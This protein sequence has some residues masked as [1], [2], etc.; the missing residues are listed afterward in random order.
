M[1]YIDDTELGWLPILETWI[2]NENFKW[3]PE[4][5]EYIFNLFKTY[6]DPCLKHVKKNLIEAMAQV[7][8]IFSIYFMQ[9][10]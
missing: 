3:K 10:T 4:T 2:S 5:K 8:F 7:M 1:V 6:I 9:L